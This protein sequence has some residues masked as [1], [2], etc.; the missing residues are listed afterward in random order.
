[1]SLV[2][3]PDS[4]DFP[5]LPESDIWKAFRNG[6]KQALE[7]IYR[8]NINELFIYGMKIKCHENLVKDCIQELF[9][10]FGMARRISHLLPV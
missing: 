7:T 5:G 8:N 4:A 2:K 3:N 1:M 6:N 10:N 9:M